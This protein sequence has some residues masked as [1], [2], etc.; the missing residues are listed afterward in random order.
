MRR[1]RRLAIRL[2]EEHIVDLVQ[3]WSQGGQDVEEELHDEPETDA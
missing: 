3:N 2:N 1:G